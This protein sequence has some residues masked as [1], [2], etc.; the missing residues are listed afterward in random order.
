LPEQTEERLDSRVW[1]IV[2]VAVLGSFLA[3]LDATIVNVSLSSLAVDLRTS[4][5]VI[6]WVTSG[7]LLA[8]ALMLPLNGWL[9]GRFGAKRLYL[10]V[11]SVLR[12][13]SA[14]CALSWS[15]TSLIGFRFLQGISGGLMAPMTQLM[16]ARVTGKHL[17]RVVGY[18]AVPV[19]LGPILGPVIAGAILQYGRWLFLIQLP[20]GILAILFAVLFLPEDDDVKVAARELDRLGFLLN[21]EIQPAFFRKRVL[22]VTDSKHLPKGGEWMRNLVGWNLRG[23]CI[24]ADKL[25]SEILRRFRD[26][27]GFHLIVIDPLYKIGG[28]REE[29]SNDQA[30]TLLN[31]LERVARETGAAIAY[32][33]HFSK[34][35]Q[36]TKESMDRVSGAGVF[37]RDPDSILMF[38]KHAT[39]GAYT[40]EA[41]LRNFA[42]FA[43]FVVRW[44]YPRF[45]RDNTLDPAE[46]KQPKKGGRSS[47]YS[48]NDLLE[49]LG[50]QDLTAKEFETRVREQ[51]G[52]SHGKFFALFQ[53]VKQAGLIH[54][55]KIDGKWEAVRK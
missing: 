5:S 48:A 47:S 4:L 29:N 6:Q 21:L 33:Q 44:E 23:H 24:D 54:K 39:D 55:C 7:Y 51:T 3:Q 52:M 34:G 8:L 12:S 16:L 36:A 46:L 18:A 19:L 22:T 25:C 38:S 20:I 2:L 40:V 37:A 43:P 31:L 49:C 17:V 42:P 35:N 50:N 45:V 28:N 26:D 13:A 41:T 14:L 1:Q 32:G 30:A 9:V 11:F 15:P 10:P 27:D 53:E